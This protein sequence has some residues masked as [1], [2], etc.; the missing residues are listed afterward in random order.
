MGL[1]VQSSDFVGF[2][3]L[4]TSAAIE[5]VIDAYIEKY[6]LRYIRKL[7]GPELGNLFIADYANTT[8]DP[9]F[10]VI[11]DPFSEQS[12]D[13]LRPVTESPTEQLYGVIYESEGLKE[14]LL[15]CIYFEYVSDRQVRQGQAG[16]A[17]SRTDTAN[18]VSMQAAQ[19]SA[20]RKWNEGLDTAEAIQWY[21]SIFKP[22]D[23]PEYKG[24][25]FEPEYSSL[26]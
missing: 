20:E 14:F 25:R 18:V 13:P 5:D 6:E 19:R 22:T 8:Q 11:E 15:S 1:I 10:A 23:Y 9:R 2:H 12:E 26:L 21:C 4:A 7:L 17:K 24:I 3:E 16:T